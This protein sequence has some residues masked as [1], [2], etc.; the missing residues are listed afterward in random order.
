MFIDIHG[1]MFAQDTYPY[2]FNSIFVH[3]LVS[4]DS[5]HHIHAAYICAHI[6]QVDSNM[7]VVY[8]WAPNK[9]KIRKKSTSNEICKV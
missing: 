4:C 1:A 7:C 3:T 8:I 5:A 9:S 6:Q 2:A